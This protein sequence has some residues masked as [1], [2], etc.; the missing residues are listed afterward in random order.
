MI[1]KNIAILSNDIR[2]LPTTGEKKLYVES[3]V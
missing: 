1:E 2:L 3:S